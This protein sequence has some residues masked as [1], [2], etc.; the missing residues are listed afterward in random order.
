MPA[1]ALW[2]AAGAIGQSVTHALRAEG[3][4]YRVV[5]RSRASLETAFGTDPVAE[6][7]TWNPDEEASVRAAAAGIETIIYV[8][9]VPYWDFRLHPILMRKTLDGAIAAGVKH[10]LL[11]G[12]VYPYGIPR[13]NPVTED[14]PREP[15]TFKGKMRKQQ[16]DLLMSADAAGKIRGAVIR[17]PDFYGPHV[18]KSLVWGAFR[19]A[20]DGTRAQLLGPIDTIH[21]F[22]YVPD[23]G[24]VVAQLIREP[25]AWGAV[26][27]FAGYGPIT[28][29][30]FANEI[31][32]QAGR[33]PKF[34]VASQWLVR[35]LGLFNPLM[36]ELG[37]MHYL[38]TTPVIMNDDRLRGLLGALN[39]TSYTEGI[40]KTFATM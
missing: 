30:A 19:A 25:K 39:K 33:E 9:G 15:H 2:G 18:D 12:T 31:F 7:A 8:V 34:M 14:H 37:E 16:E 6:I 3:T 27:H 24:P 13:T 29:R 40:R 11:I 5:G 1:I 20:K 38:L 21:E 35:L 22:V 26:W 36:R 28:I 32:A 17:L 10:I 4:P 23:V